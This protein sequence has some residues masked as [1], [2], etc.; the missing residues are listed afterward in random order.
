MFSTSRLDIRLSP[1][2][3][4]WT[5]NCSV[6][7]GSDVILI[8]TKTLIVTTPSGMSKHFQILMKVYIYVAILL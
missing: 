3:Q 7:N 1:D 2:L 5:I 4:G 8:G 6:D